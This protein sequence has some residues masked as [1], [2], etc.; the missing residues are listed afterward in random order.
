MTYDKTNPNP[1]HALKGLPNVDLL[2]QQTYKGI[3]HA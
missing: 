3:F 2:Q 1:K